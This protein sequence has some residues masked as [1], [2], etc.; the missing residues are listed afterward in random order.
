MK[1]VDEMKNEKLGAAI[2]Y[3][4]TK[5]CHCVPMKLYDIVLPLIYNDTFMTTVMNYHNFDEC[6]EVCKNNDENFANNV[7][8]HYEAYE[9][10]TSKSLGIAMIEKS[11]SFEI[12]DGILVGLPNDG[13][14]LDLL[15]AIRLGEML[16]GKDLDKVLP[17][18][19]SDEFKIVFLD[20]N[21]VGDDIDFSPLK[22]AGNTT[23][24]RDVDPENIAEAIKDAHCV[25]TNKHYLGK[26]ELH[27][28][29]NLELICVTATGYNNIDI[30]YCKER[31]I[32]VCNVKSYSTNSVAQ[33]T[34]SLALAL[35]N[36]IDY[37]NSYVKSG[38]YSS[39]LLFTHFGHTFNELEGKTWGI[40]GMGEI[41]RKVASMAECFGCNVQYY[42]TSGLNN[43]QDYKQVDF[44][45][46]LKTSDIITIHAPLNKDTENLFDEA[47]FMLMKEDAYLVNVGRGKIVNE[48][49][50]VNA[51]NEGRI[52]GAGIDVFENEPLSSDSPLLTI[53]DNSRLLLTPHVAWAAVES[54]NRVIDEVAQNIIAYKNKNPRNVC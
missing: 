6:I 33:Y 38:D 10:M 21:T 19:I 54:R 11:V 3:N 27:G 42:S 39:S 31:N 2:M 51:L 12:E 1:I 13:E 53:Q 24:L 14:F 30:D 18:F 35:I 20:S 34:M 25:V 43:E 9:E 48:G 26:I 46:L 32:T 22:N 7:L 29:N 37:Y 5:G 4:F 52:R 28:V 8:N 15:E 44:K 16:Q 41:G 47:A 23:F 40:V 36:Q 49:D 45:T 50:L 17:L